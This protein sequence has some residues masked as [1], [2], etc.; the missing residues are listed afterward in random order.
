LGN[1]VLAGWSGMD[2][3]SGDE[4]SDRLN[5]GSGNDVLY[6][7]G[8]GVQVGGSG[9]DVLFGDAGRDELEGGLGTDNLRGGAGVDRIEGGSNNDRLQGDGG[10]DTFLF[11]LGSALDTIIDFTKGQG[12]IDLSGY[13]GILRFGDLTRSTSASSTILDRGFSNGGPSG[14]EVLPIQGVVGLRA[15]DFILA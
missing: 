4:G 9:N 1:D 10:A 13:A 14:V 5:G 6:G 8:D 11:A 2:L 3:L 7:G 15:T 12:L